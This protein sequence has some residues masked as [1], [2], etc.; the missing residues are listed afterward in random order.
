[1]IEN[2]Y[3]KYQNG[4]VVFY[5]TGTKREHLELFDKIK[6]PYKNYECYVGDFKDINVDN[7][8]KLENFNIITIKEIKNDN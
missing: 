7:L 3:T 2:G 6:F 1:M 4:G 8:D 5:M